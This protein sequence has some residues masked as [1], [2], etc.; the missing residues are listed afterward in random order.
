MSSFFFL[1][2]SDTSED[3]IRQFKHEALDLTIGTNASVYKAVAIK[4]RRIV[5]LARLFIVV[6]GQPIWWGIN[7]LKFGYPTSLGLLSTPYPCV[8]GSS[9][10]L[11]FYFYLSSALSSRLL[12]LLKQA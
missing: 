11:S 5:I 10:D 2:K 8:H 1:L 9:S 12:L 7:L 3:R 4:P 6:V